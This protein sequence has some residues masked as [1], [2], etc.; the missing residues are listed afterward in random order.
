[1]KSGFYLVNEGV[2]WH[3]E[4]ESPPC[5]ENEACFELNER[6]VIDAVAKDGGVLAN[7]RAR[8][9]FTQVGLERLSRLHLA[10]DKIGV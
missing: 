3:T 5:G 4:G 7:D 9:K 6:E 2:I 10:L 8:F 1:M